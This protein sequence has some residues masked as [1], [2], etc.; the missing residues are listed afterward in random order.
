V[1][2]LIRL[3]EKGIRVYRASG[4][5]RRGPLVNWEARIGKVVKYNRA[6]SVAYVIWD[7]RQSLDRVEA[8][9]IEPCGAPAE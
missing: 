8:E 4:G 5:S 9:L 3:N 6:R 1:T 7:G 2:D